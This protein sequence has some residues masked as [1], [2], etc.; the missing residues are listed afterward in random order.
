MHLKKEKILRAEDVT[1][2]SLESN[3][4]R[5]RVEII[6]EDEFKLTMTLFSSDE[7]EYY[8]EDDITQTLEFSS[9]DLERLIKILQMARKINCKSWRTIIQELKNNSSN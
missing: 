2:Q 4:G 8:T 6:D 1:P 9:D 5:F 3:D 7:P